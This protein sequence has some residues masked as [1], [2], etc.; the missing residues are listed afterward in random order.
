MVSIRWLIKTK[1]IEPN[2]EPNNSINSINL[3]TIGQV[4]QSRNSGK[5]LIY[6]ALW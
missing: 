2:F 4:Y 5:T 1:V 3:A 6:G